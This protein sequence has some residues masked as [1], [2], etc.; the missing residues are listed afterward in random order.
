MDGERIFG[1]RNIFLLGAA[2]LPHQPGSSKLPVALDGAG[3]GFRDF[4]YFFLAEAGEVTQ[5]DHF[6]LARGQLRKG[7]QRRI[8][9]AE[10]AKN[11]ARCCQST[12]LTSTNRRYTSLTRAVA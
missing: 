11:C 6:S 8:I 9:C 3:G 4:G 5:L 1:G 2:Q 10:I 7:L 12:F